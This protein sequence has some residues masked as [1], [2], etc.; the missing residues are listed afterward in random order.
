MYTCSYR[1]PNQNNWLFSP[2]ICLQ[3]A[4]EVLFNVTYRF[5]QCRDIEDCDNDF[6]TVHRYDV[7][8]PAFENEQINP[9]NYVLLSTEDDSK[10]KQKPAPARDVRKVVHLNRPTPRRN[11]FHLGF[12]DTGTCG[13]VGRVFVYYTVC[14]AKKIGLVEYR[15][16]ANPPKNG[17][18]EVFQA[19][20]VCNAHPLTSLDVT[21]FRNG[22]C[23]DVAAGG[24]RCECDDG[25]RL[26][27]DGESC[28]GE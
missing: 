10:L 21:A 6:V 14:E 24:A 7:D 17:P 9:D 19:R 1:L 2:F 15:E 5:D 28:I 18:D 8:E 11:G 4:K 23:I 3:D 20:C 13:Q 25:Y 12:H 26:S 27:E 16:Y 22:S